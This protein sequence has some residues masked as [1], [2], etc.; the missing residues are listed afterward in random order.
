ML[1]AVRALATM[2]NLSDERL[3]KIAHDFGRSQVVECEIPV[4]ILINARKEY[5]NIENPQDAWTSYAQIA[6][7]AEVLMD[8]INDLS[9]CAELNPVEDL[10]KLTGDFWAKSNA[11]SRAIDN[12]RGHSR[13]H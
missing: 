6:A 12:V 5:A 2:C 1:E 11:L 7:L 9:R 8:S 4:E 3:D 10:Y 13:E